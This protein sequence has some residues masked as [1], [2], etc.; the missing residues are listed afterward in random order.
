MQLFWSVRSLFGQSFWAMNKS[1]LLSKV[2]SICAR[3][4]ALAQ[5]SA[6]W[7]DLEQLRSYFFGLAAL[8]GS[9]PTIL[10]QKDR[11]NHLLTLQEDSFVIKCLH[12]VK[13]KQKGQLDQFFCMWASVGCPPIILDCKSW[14]L[15]ALPKICS[16]LNCPFLPFTQ[17]M[18]YVLK[19]L[20]LI[21]FKSTP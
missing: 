18:L 9:P 21:Y 6:S 17:W 3:M 11:P 1:I 4:Q 13:I 8:V 2:K 10:A 20:D 19:T 12:P 5:F 16:Q 14:Q 15:Y 7:A